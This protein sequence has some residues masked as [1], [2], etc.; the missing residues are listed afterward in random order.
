VRCRSASFVARVPGG[1][2]SHILL[3]G[4]AEE[5]HYNPGAMPM[6]QSGTLPDLLDEVT[7][8][9]PDRGAVVASDERLTYAQ[10]RARVRQLAK[11]PL[12]PLHVGDASTPKGVQLAHFALIE[13]MFNIGEPW[14]RMPGTCRV[15]RRSASAPCGSLGWRRRGHF[16]E[17]RRERSS[18][19]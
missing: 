9:D 18:A 3:I 5:R 17:S 6:P 2:H 19:R 8:R 1:W 11:G 16:R 15:R 12:H 14:P 13:N 10:Y 4:R 7:A